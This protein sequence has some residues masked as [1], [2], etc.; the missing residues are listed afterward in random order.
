MSKLNVEHHLDCKL[1]RFS[2]ISDSRG[3]FYESFNEEISKITGFWPKQENVSKSVKGVIRGLHMQH[4]PPAAKLIRVVSG[5]IRDVAVDFRRS[6][7]SYGK[8]VYVDLDDSFP[9][10]F[11]IPEGHL[12]GFSVLSEHAVVNYLVSAPYVPGGEI[13]V[14]PFSR[15]L[16]IDWKITRE[17]SLQSEKDKNAI[18][19][20]EI[21]L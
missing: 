7:S 18:D 15:S 5:K 6:S 8:Y 17:E 12:H 4:S 13:S 9:H 3:F 2:L 16:G 14:N 11:L 21:N 19:F 1:I 20:E 10:W